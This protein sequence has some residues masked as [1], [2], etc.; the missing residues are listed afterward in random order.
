MKRFH[1]F[2]I[3]SAWFK[4]H[5]QIGKYQPRTV[6]DYL[7]ELSFFR[8]FIEKEY[9]ITDIDDMEIQDLYNYTAFLYERTLAP[10]TIAHKL[11][12]IKCFFKTLYEQ[13]KLYKDLSANLCIPRSGKTLPRKILT[14]KEIKKAFDYLEKQISK[15]PIK[16]FADALLLRNWAVFE[17]FYSTGMRLNEFLILKIGDVNFDDG[18]VF[19]RG[20]GAR[21]K[22]TPVGSVCLAVLTRYLKESR[23][24]LAKADSDYLFVSTHGKSISAEATRE[25]VRGIC[26]KAKIEKKVCVHSLRHSCATHMLNNGADIRYVQELLGHRCL[27]STQVYT[28]VSI[29]KLKNTHSKHHPRE[30]DNFIKGKESKNNGKEAC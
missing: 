11:S 9:H 27:S 26:K 19:I 16:T 1:Q 29:Q 12:A 2:D 24:I 28:H 7:F 6:D 23:P 3:L 4:E 18:M 20:K 22:V 13:N 5:L 25:I 8:R 30:K 14:E 15:K 10:K 21:E 17:L